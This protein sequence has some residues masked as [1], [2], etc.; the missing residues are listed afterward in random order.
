MRIN[1]SM[2]TELFQ[3]EPGIALMMAPNDDF[4]H[5]VGGADGKKHLLFYERVLAKPGRLEM[6]SG[7]SLVCC[8]M[9]RILAATRSDCAALQLGRSRRLANAAHDR[10][11]LLQPRTPAPLAE[12]L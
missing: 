7:L 11:V 4:A 8:R 2:R 3:W 10:Q 5:E 6:V 1:E 12:S 9:A